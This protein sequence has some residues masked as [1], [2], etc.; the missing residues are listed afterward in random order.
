MRVI[1]VRSN[2]FQALTKRTNEIL[3]KIDA[4]FAKAAVT[5]SDPVADSTRKNIW[6][7]WVTVD[8]PGDGYNQLTRMLT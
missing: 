4:E 2:G 5:V 8:V 6:C 1:P 7:A 3:S